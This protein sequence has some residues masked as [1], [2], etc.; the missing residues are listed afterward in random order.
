MYSSK[1]ID[2][3]A[4]RCTASLSAAGLTVSA[5][6]R[7]SEKAIDLALLQL[8]GAAAVVRC[9]EKATEDDARALRVMLAQ[10]DFQRA[11]LVY[12]AEDQPHLSGEIETYPLAR[13]DELAA[14]LAR[15]SAP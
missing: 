6:V 14:S 5:A 15:E 9:V 4:Q 8:G 1:L 13:I 10:G 12:A 3:T 2:L 7:E 11:A